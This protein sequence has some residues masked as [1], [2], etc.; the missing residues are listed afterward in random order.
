MHTT[1]VL[2]C[3]GQIVPRQR[4]CAVGKIV[5]PWNLAPLVMHAAMMRAA[6]TDAAV[7]GVQFLN[8]LLLSSDDVN[9]CLQHAQNDRADRICSRALCSHGTCGP[10]LDLLVDQGK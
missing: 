2:V 8:F 1:F 5:Q 9:F 7:F 3:A 4:E 10:R 6:V